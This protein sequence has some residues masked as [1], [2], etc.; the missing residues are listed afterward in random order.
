MITDHRNLIKPIVGRQYIAGKWLDAGAE[1]FP[2]QNP[3]RL[4]EV[5]GVFPGAG[6]ELAGQAVAPAVSAVPYR[7]RKSRVYPAD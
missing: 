5:I 4:Q 2:S 7:R 1:P 6:A 3:A